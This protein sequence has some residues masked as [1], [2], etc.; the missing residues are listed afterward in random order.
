MDQEF[1]RGNARVSIAGIDEFR[2]WIGG[3]ANALGVVG[4]FKASA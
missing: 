2:S 3:P 4:A 1:C